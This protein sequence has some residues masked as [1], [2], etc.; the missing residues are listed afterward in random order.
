MD[1]SSIV[2]PKEGKLKFRVNANHLTQF[3]M[4]FTIYF[5]PTL[6]MYLFIL[7]M[8]HVCSLDSVIMKGY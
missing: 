7:I 6:K 2:L 5:K 3:Y 8:T 1:Q 4:S